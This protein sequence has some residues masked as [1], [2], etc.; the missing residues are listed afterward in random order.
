MCAAEKNARTSGTSATIRLSREST[1]ARGKARRL[2]DKS[3]SVRG[4]NL[5][6]RYSRDCS[7]HR[8]S[9]SRPIRASTSVSL[10]L[11]KTSPPGVSIICSSFRLRASPPIISRSSV[12]PE[13]S[14]F[15]DPTSVRRAHARAGACASRTRLRVTGHATYILF[16]SRMRMWTT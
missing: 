11:N 16:P 14:R 1:K 7:L 8:V 5:S 6:R 12:S 3:V 9:I 15:R 10:R 4:V 2:L 13:E